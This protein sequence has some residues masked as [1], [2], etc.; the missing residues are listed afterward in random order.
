MPSPKASIDY[1]HSLSQQDRQRPSEH[2]AEAAGKAE[3]D[4]GKKEEGI[5]TH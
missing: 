4:A 5:R 1:Y 2:P 3:T